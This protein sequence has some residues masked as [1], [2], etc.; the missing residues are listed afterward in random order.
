[1]KGLTLALNKNKIM[2]I[3]ENMSIVLCVMF[4][5]RIIFFFSEEY[6]TLIFG[7]VLFLIFKYMRDKDDAKIISALAISFGLWG[8]LQGYI[9]FPSFLSLVIWIE[10]LG[11]FSAFCFIGVPLLLTFTLIVDENIEGISN[12]SFD[13]T[14]VGT[15]T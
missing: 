9:L 2:K 15:S 13:I 1:M 11:F 5:L 7:I 6:Y 14:I 4:L 8:F 3:A 10:D 12:F